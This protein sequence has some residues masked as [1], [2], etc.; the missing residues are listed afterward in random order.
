MTDVVLKGDT[1]KNVASELPRARWRHRWRSSSSG[2]RA[3]RTHMSTSVWSS[4]VRQLPGARTDPYTHRGPRSWR[5]LRFFL[6]SFVLPFDP[7][8]MEG[9]AAAGG[10]SALPEDADA[11]VGAGYGMDA[12]DLGMRWIFYIHACISHKGRVNACKLRFHKNIQFIWLHINWKH[13]TV[14][15]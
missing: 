12:A 9:A 5:P 3:N 10:C 13:L 6:I 1:R 15:Y 8:L 7:G 4:A 11:V 14:S 2:A